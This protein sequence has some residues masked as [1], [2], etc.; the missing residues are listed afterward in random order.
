MGRGNL[1]RLLGHQLQNLVDVPN[2]PAEFTANIHLPTYVTPYK[3]KWITVQ[4]SQSWRDFTDC[5][6]AYS[7]HV[8]TMEANQASGVEKLSAASATPRWNIF[9]DFRSRFFHPHVVGD[10][11]CHHR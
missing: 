7:N 11:G 8:V 3:A 1:E 9:R 4:G 5:R 6:E 2:K 10:P